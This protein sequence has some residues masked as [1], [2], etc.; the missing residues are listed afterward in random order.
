MRALGWLMQFIA[1]WH[2][3]SRKLKTLMFLR[4]ADVALKR[5]KLSC[6]ENLYERQRK[7]K[8]SCWGEEQNRENDKKK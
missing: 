8:V 4:F 6:P 5:F 2:E 3:V 7:K 1:M